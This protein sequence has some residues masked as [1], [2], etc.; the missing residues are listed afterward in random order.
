MRFYL[1]FR[2]IFGHSFQLLLSRS[3]T[4]EEKELYSRWAYSLGMSLRLLREFLRQR[5]TC[6][7]ISS[8]AS[9]SG[10]LI[11]GNRQRSFQKSSARNPRLPLGRGS[12]RNGVVLPSPMHLIEFSLGLQH[13]LL[14]LNRLVAEASLRNGV[15]LSPRAIRLRPS[16][17]RA[18][19]GAP[20]AGYPVGGRLLHFLPAWEMI[21][22]NAFVLSVIR[23]GYRIDIADSIPNGVIRLRPPALPALHRQHISQEVSL[24][25]QK[26]AIETVRDHPML[27]LSPVFVIPKRSGKLRVILNMREINTYIRTEHFRM[28]TLASILPT[29]EAEDLAISLDLMD[30]YF[31][32]PIH[33]ASRDL[34]G[35]AFQGQTFRYRALPFGLRPAPRVFTRIV[36][37]LAAFLRDRDL[38]LFTYLDG[39]LL[40]A[41]SEPKLRAQLSFLLHITQNLGF[42]VN[43]EKSEL[44]PT[45]TPIY[46][47]C[48]DRY[49]EPSRPAQPRQI[50][51][52]HFCCPNPQACKQ[53][54]S[55][56]LFTVSRLSGQ[57]GRDRD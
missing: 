5:S 2:G 15:A 11:Q 28:E 1:P 6:L 7:G 33:P 31:H 35:F 27:S 41:N 21:T 52:N 55:Q 50:S 42:L 38:R 39:W 26:G 23:G 48:G 3:Q 53:S 10:K 19:E 56:N 47:G 16:Q 13:L 12:R 22:E 20:R 54:D 29:P 36:S 34:L 44:S 25:L 32:I 24:L 49:T 17:P 45:H 8:L 57:S 46:F 30:A 51:V 9:C 14:S 43:W 4:P 40:V 37:A 18:F